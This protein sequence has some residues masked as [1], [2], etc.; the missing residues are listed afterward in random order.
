MN[1]VSTLTGMHSIN[2]AMLSVTDKV[3]EKLSSKGLSLKPYSYGFCILDPWKIQ[4][5]SVKEVSQ[6]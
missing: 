1:L 5:I 6:S 4:P 2:S 3:G